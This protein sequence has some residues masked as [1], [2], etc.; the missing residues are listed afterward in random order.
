MCDHEE[1]DELLM[2]HI[3]IEM[4]VVISSV[5]TDVF[6]YS[7][8]KICGC[9]VG[10]DQLV[11][12]QYLPAQDIATTLDSDVIDIMP[13]LHAFTACDSTK[14]AALETAESDLAELPTRFANETLS[15]AEEFL[16]HCGASKS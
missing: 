11:V 7:F 5:D 14:K 4:K 1:A 9:C 6:V 2:F 13:S 12:E 15:P 3:N 16:V 10:K 8:F